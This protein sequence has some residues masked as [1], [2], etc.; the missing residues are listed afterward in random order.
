MKQQSQQQLTDKFDDDSISKQELGKLRRMLLENI[1]SNIESSSNEDVK[2]YLD[3]KH[4][5]IDR[6]KLANLIGYKTKPVNLRQSFKTEIEEAEKLLKE[7]GVIATEAKN[8]SQVHDDNVS[9]FLTFIQVRLVKAEPAYHWPVNNKGRLF[10][11]VIWAF[12]LNQSPN[13]IKSAPS[14]FYRN[15]DVKRALADIDIKLANEEIL[16]TLDYASESALDEMND[17]M[18]SA[19][20]TKYRQQIKKANEILAS[21]R[22][23]RR[24]LE[25]KIWELEDELNIYKQNKKKLSNLE[26]KSDVKL[27]S[28]R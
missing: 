2:Q 13:E 1:L 16:K 19:A 12:F 5:K 20:L 9:R 4:S 23:E 25:K 10:H 22:E 27:V 26:S 8:N 28:V 3:K 14:L 15:N 6:A 11:R 7:R 21:E 18:T 17:N 24:K